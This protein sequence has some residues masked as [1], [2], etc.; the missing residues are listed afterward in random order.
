MKVSE[1]IETL[2]ELPSDA[3]IMVC[4]QDDFGS[5]YMEATEVDPDGDW[6]VIR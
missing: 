2:R 3:R 1:L 5:T 4:E 6:V